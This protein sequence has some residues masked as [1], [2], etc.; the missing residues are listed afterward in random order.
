METGKYFI[1]NHQ[2][3]QLVSQVGWKAAL[4]K[5]REHIRWRLRQK[6]LS[7]VH[8][9]ANLG[10]DPVDYYLGISYEKLLTGA[11]EWKDEHT[12]GQQ[13]IR[14]ADS[15]ISKEIEKA[16]SAKANAFKVV[17]T[18]VEQ[19]FYDLAAP[20][21]D[22]EEHQDMENRLL[23]IENAVAGDE[24]LEFMVEGLKEG[25]KRSEL[26]DLLNI[27]VRQLDKLREKLIRRIKTQQ[28]NK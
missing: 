8:T 9:S 4:A 22:D 19:E 5:C 6:T 13:M 2:K 25:K 23:M 10:E 12:L 28:S 16:T 3:I 7:G 26:A 21:I 18:D 24:Q 11:W 17:Y 1:A 14:I 20:P 27:G 15:Y